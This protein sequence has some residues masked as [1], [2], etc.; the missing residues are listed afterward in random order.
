[1]TLTPELL[2]D[3]R[4]TAEAAKEDVERWQVVV[5]E[6]NNGR[7]RPSTVL[8]LLDRIAELDKARLEAIATANTRWGDMQDAADR[9]KD[10]RHR[11]EAAEKR[12]VELETIYVVPS[13]W[14]CDGCGDIER[15][16]DGRRPDMHHGCGG[17]WIRQE[18]TA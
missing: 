1:M 4:K 10:Q 11:A 7:C 5:P 16:E 14:R 12:V 3:L 18:R 13:Q 15:P 6:W 2:A 9:E 8:A 17:R